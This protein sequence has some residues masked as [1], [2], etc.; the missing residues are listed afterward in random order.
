MD[1]TK[2][3]MNKEQLDQVAGGSFVYPEDKVKK[4][5]VYMQYADGTPG[6]FGY[7]W[8]S[9]DYYFKGKKITEEQLDCL[10]EFSERYGFP[11][12]TYEDAYRDHRF[13]I[14][15]SAR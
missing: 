9:G 2:N 7:I 10:I 5:G 3:E 4:A 14:R 1:D 8:N 12:P 13:Q 6:S 15:R 11:A